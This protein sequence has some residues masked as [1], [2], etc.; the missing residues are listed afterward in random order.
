MPIL[1]KVIYRFYEILIKIP[2]AFFTGIEK[3]TKISMEPQETQN[4]PRN[5]D[6]EDGWQHHISRIQNILQSHSNQKSIALAYM[7]TFIFIY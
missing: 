3:Y 4:N 6:Q 7:F 1:S 2:M 5:L